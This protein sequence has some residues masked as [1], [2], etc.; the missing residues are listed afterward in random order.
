MFVARSSTWRYSRSQSRYL[1]CFTKNLR[2]VENFLRA[3]PSTRATCRDFCRFST[4]GIHK[5][6]KARPQSEVAPRLPN[7]LTVTCLQSTHVPH[8]PSPVPAPVDTIDYCCAV[9]TRC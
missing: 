8:A 3:T 1:S 2:F 4:H 6:Q 7:L 5:R 9:D